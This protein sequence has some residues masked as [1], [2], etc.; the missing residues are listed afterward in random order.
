MIGFVTSYSRDERT[1]A[2]IRLANF[3]VHNSSISSVRF[4]LPLTSLRSS[5]CHDWDK[6]TRIMSTEEI[7]KISIWIHFGVYPALTDKIND[8]DTD[9]LTRHILVVPWHGI[10]KEQLPFVRGA[11]AG[12]VCPSPKIASNFTAAYKLKPVPV[13][14]SAIWLPEQES[15]IRTG[16][17]V[18]NQI[19]AMVLVDNDGVDNSIQSI[20]AAAESVLSGIPNLHL[21]FVLSRKVTAPVYRKAFDQFVHRHHSRITVT[22]FKTFTELPKLMELNDWVWLT[23]RFA[24]FGYFIPLALQSGCRVLAWD[25]HPHDQYIVPGINGYLIPCETATNWLGAPSAINDTS[26]AARMATLAFGSRPSG[27]I[28]RVDALKSQSFETVW[29]DLLFL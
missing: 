13:I 10:T 5:V 29:T 17:V 21:S 11:Y 22:Y 26:A 1:A 9:G 12:F 18:P 19:R 28:P 16:P 4:M 3:I 7:K 6:Q 23:S 20:M 24:D 25:V 27:A 8:H 14:E 15:I 2:A